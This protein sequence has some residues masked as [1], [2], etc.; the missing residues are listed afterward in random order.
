MKRVLAV[1]LLAAC[2]L[3]FSP[4]LAAQCNIGSFRGTYCLSCNGWTD[5]STL[6]PNL[7]KG[8]APASHLGILKLDG[9]GH[10]SGWHTSNMGGL[11][12]TMDI[13]DLTYTV[14]DDCAVQT[15]Y[16]L[17]IRELGVTMGPVTRVLVGVPS[18]PSGSAGYGMEMKGLNVGAGP[19]QDVTPCELKLISP[20]P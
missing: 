8:Y 2:V 1:A 12:L 19:G 3:L 15:T 14:N 10:G 9:A 16:S 13:V 7:P 17:R 6:N 18:L 5:L 11:A 4:N 20:R